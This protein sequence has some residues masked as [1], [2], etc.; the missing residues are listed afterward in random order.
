M[1]RFYEEDT[2]AFELVFDLKTFKNRYAT[3][4]A[5][6]SNPF[7]G[8]SEFEARDNEWKRRMVVA[9]GECIEILC[10]PEDVQRSDSGCKGHD[11]SIICKHCMIPFCRRCISKFLQ[12]SESKIPPMCLANDNFWGYTTDV[13]SRYQVRYIELAIASPVWTNCMVFYIEGDKGHLLNEKAFSKTYRTVARGLPMSFVMPAMD[14]LSDL[15]RKCADKDLIEIPAPQEC[16]KYLLRVHVRAGMQDLG[17][18][19]T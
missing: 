10:C 8:A 14:I 11:P 6:R 2:A 7:E 5:N 13:I 3:D 4:A 9:G 16:L 15:T 18:L 1:F 19:Y 17:T 12:K